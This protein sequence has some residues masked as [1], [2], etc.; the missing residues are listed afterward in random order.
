MAKGAEAVG[1]SLLLFFSISSLLPQVTEEAGGPGLVL[2]ALK[3]AF[4][5]IVQY[6]YGNSVGEYVNLMNI[7]LKVD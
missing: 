1:G 3:A 7:C 5:I 6:K 4:I 2:V